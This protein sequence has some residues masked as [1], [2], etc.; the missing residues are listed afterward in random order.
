MYLDALYK[1]GATK[2]KEK[3]KKFNF[4]QKTQHFIAP[5]KKY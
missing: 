3:E 5:L 1:N 4:K 2:E